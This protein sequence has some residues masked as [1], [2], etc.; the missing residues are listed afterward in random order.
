MI[1]YKAKL[2]GIT[3]HEV[4]EA[5]TSKCSSLDLE[6]IK[7]HKQYVGNQIKRGL[8]KGSSYLLNA[9]VN[10]ALNI[11]RKVVGDDFIQNLSDRGCWFQLVRIRDMF[12][13]SHEQFVLKTV[14]IS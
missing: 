4:D 12:Q 3:I 9:D 10:G 2:V 7:K 5:Y 11:L 13:T 8:F 14:T 6:P 1:T